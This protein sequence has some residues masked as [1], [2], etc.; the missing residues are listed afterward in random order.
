MGLMSG[1]V[2]VGAI[3]I[4]AVLATVTVTPGAA[5]ASSSPKLKLL[6]SEEFNGKKG[7]APS[8]K[9]W[10]FNLGGPNSNGELEYY[11]SR[12]SNISMDG[13]GHLKITANRIADQGY[14]TVGTDPMAEN[15]L[16][17]CQA[18]QFTSGFIN[19]S[20]KLSF[21]YGM[22]SV[23][24]KVP[25]GTGTWPAFWMLGS[26]ILKGIPWPDAGEIDISEVKGEQP[27]AAYGTVHGPGMESNGGGYGSVYNGDYIDLSQDYHVYSIMWKKN[28]IDWY[29]DN[30]LYFTAK[31]GDP[32][33]GTWVYN[34]PFYLLLNLAMGG[35]F[36]N[37]GIDP[38]IK[39]AQL[40]V[41]YIRYYS[42]NG[43][44]KVFHN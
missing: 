20:H 36:G 12:A 31:A 11:T 41:D 34:Q 5:S 24:M 4:S 6:W 22:V 19:T 15:I 2:I 42:V 1:R 18:C 32:S 16:N 26:S 44:G 27:N 40:S 10:N 39:Q 13:S 38:A 23:K 8:P 28:E 29:V 25:S 7:S 30:N 3:L 35:T 43:V 37:N 17:A 33:A 9:S 14:N 21:Q